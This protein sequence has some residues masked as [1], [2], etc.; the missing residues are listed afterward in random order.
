MERREAIITGTTEVSGAVVAATLTTIVVFIPIVYLHGAS[1]QLFKELAWTVTFSLLS[2]LFVA[3]LVIPML[4]DQFTKRKGDQHE[5]VSVQFKGYG[6]H[7][8]WLLARRGGSRYRGSDTCRC[9]LLTL[10][11]Y[12]FLPV[13]R[14]DFTVSVKLPEGTRLERTDAGGQPGVLAAFSEPG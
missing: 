11:R 1:G 14:K 8:R 6:N 5:A 12:R 10:C 4:Y 7:L 9:Y 2:S 3:L 13:P